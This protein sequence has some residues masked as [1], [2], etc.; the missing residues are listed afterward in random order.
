VEYAQ[1]GDPREDREAPDHHARE[2]GRPRELTY[3][4]TKIFCLSFLALE[5]T[6]HWFLLLLE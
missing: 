3:L 2:A 1:H 5:I 6:T 4:R